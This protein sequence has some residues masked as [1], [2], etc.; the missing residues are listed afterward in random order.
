MDFKKFTI[1][2]SEAVQTAHNLALQMKH[3]KIETIHLL[4]AMLDQ[5]D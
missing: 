4:F 2:A 5:K 1:K 3:N